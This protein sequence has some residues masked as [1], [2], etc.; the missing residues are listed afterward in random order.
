MF[1]KLSK[2]I[3]RRGF[4]AGAAA[5]GAA[6]TAAL[7]LDGC[8]G[9]SSAE[10]ELIEG[11][12][13]EFPSASVEYLDV[14]ES[15]VLPYTGMSSVESGDYLVESNSFDLPLGSLV[16][17]C[18]DSQALLIM[19]GASS[20]SLIQLCMADLNE[21]GYTP[22]LGQSLGGGED[23]V[24]YDARASTS[25][26]AWVECNMM[27]GLWRV[28]ATTLTD[29]LA[30]EESMQ[31]AALLDEGGEDYSPPLLA[32]G[33][34][35]VFW[36]VM[37]DPNGP[38]SSEDSYLKAA[39]FVTGSTGVSAKPQVIY[40]SHGRMITNPLVSGDVLTIVP[41]VTTDSVYYQLTTLDIMTNQVLNVSI[42][43]P[44]LRVSDAVWLGDGFAFGIEGNYD[45]ARGLAFAG[46]Y[47][48]LGDGQYLYVN[49]PPVSPPLL[50]NS[51]TYVKSTKN[52]IGLDTATGTAVIIDTPKDCVDYGD[53][54]AGVGRQD[55]LVLYT[56][57]TSK[58]GQ[59]AGVC[60]VRVFD[61]L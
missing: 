47:R 54:L 60:H 27:H 50:M 52:V 38:A 51:L 34:S 49:K 12:Q 8:C 7:A 2:K 15:Q 18:S 45:Y 3:T 10:E 48:Q 24:V 61:H 23:Y 46:T 59:D 39:E 43:P 14:N 1:T 6:T 9:G 25:A 37:P 19:P 53:V 17:Q 40:T 11:V 58:K 33:G 16:H 55:R 31:Q 41:R 32:V 21:G 20:K 13:E 29:G 42:L 56:T 4:V 35:K 26:I 36:T 5:T 28:Y 30:S 44:S 22:I 57:V